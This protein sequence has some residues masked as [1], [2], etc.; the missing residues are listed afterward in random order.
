[1][2]NYILHINLKKHKKMENKTNSVVTTQKD[3]QIIRQSQIKVSLEFF[4]ACGACPS[5]VDLVKVTTMLENFIVNGYKGSDIPKY[6][7]LDKYINET[8][9]VHQNG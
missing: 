6:E 7:A 3:L 2:Y 9:K 8:Y 5:I 4:A 1:M